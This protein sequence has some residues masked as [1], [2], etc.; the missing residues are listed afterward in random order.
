M[1]YRS[2]ILYSYELTLTVR[3]KKFGTRFDTSGQRD[4]FF[5]QFNQLEINEILIKY[6]RFFKLENEMR[7]WFKNWYEYRVVLSLPWKKF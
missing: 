1:R 2:E 6:L 7:Y 3:E 4:D 5:S